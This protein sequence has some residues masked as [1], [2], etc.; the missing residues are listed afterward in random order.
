MTPPIANNVLSALPSVTLVT[1]LISM[2]EVYQQ[3]EKLKS[4]KMKE[5]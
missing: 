4:R 5:G 3:A 2:V 1:F